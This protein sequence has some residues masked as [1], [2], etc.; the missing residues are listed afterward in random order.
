MLVKEKERRRNFEGEKIK[1]RGERRIKGREEKR[2][3]RNNGEK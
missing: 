3:N 2:E 1:G